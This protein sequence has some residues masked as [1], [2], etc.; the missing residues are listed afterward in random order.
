MPEVG[1][2]PQ[3]TQGDRLRK[4]RDLTGLNSYDFAD[5]IGVSQKTISNAESERTK[6]RKIMLN[7]WGLATGVPVEWLQ[8]GVEPNDHDGGGT[9]L[10]SGGINP[11]QEY[12]RPL[13]LVAA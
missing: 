12:A 9:S 13:A 8:T 1:I 7:A 3:F 2:I 10:P 4:A 11:T 6:P 5:E